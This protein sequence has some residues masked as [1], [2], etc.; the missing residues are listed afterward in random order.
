VNSSSVMCSGE[1]SMEDGCEQQFGTVFRGG[2]QWR[3]VVNSSS[4][5]RSEEAVHCCT[6]PCFLINGQ[7]LYLPC[8]F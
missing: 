2:G 5:S 4:V 8:T 3:T 6:V 1:G 7:S